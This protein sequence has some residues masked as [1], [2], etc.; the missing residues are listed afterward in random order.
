MSWFSSWL[1]RAA[2]V[3]ALASRSDK[4]WDA[5]EKRLR[6]LEVVF[7]SDTSMPAMIHTLTKRLE[8]LEFRAGQTDHRL[9]QI[10]QPQ[11]GDFK[12]IEDNWLALAKRLSAVERR[13][14]QRPKTGTKA[15]PPTMTAQ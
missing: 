1:S 13:M 14:E 10:G 7:A 12:I 4:R 8:K 9:M 3:D 5:L 11:A 15:I 6:R 2:G